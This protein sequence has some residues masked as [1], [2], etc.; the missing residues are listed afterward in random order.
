MAMF[1]NTPAGGDHDFSG[2]VVVVTGAAS[3]IGFGIADA[4]SSVGA[5]V[6][7][8][9]IDE[10]A[11]TAAASMLSG[12]PALA[13]RTDVSDRSEVEHLADVAWDAFG[14]V[15]IVVNNAGVLPERAELV[16]SSGEEARWV[17]E[18]NVFGVWHGISVFGKRFIQ[19]CTPA[20][21]VNTGS[22]HS[23]GMPHT[24]AGFYTASKHAILALSDVLR[25]ELPDYIKVSV[26][27]PG[28]VQT[29]L[30]SAARNR[31]D[32]FGGPVIAEGPPRLIEVGLLP[33]EVGDLVVAGVSAG[34]F[35]IF[36]HPQVRKFV[37]QR[38]DEMLAA[39]EAQSG[40]PAS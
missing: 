4:F 27:C 28:A 29:H 38:Y 7:L 33:R 26:L 23:V 1:D 16:Q 13:V 35:Y 3:G 37:D 18:V 32:R 11:V 24:H 10:Q 9:D 19:Q 40:Q 5:E 34:H 25:K 39:F 20:H 36:T 21:I 30:L 22:E 6:V 14:H 12:Q 31:Q 2:K 17:F 15:D 8:S